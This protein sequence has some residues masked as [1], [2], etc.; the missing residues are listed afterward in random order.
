MTLT[1][2]QP[3]VDLRGGIADLVQRQFDVLSGDGFGYWTRLTICSRIGQPSL[4]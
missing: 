3:P 1:G 2:G 4:A